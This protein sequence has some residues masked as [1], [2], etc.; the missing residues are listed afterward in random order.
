MGKRIEWIDQVKGFGIFLVV[1]GHNFPITEKYIYSFHMP[2]FFVV[3]GFFHPIIQNHKAIIKRAKTILVPY[4]LWSFL[5]FIF[6]AVLGRS[7]GES[8]KHN[9][10]VFKNFIGVFYAQGDREYMDW[11]IPMWF[12][13]TIFLTFLLFYLLQNIKGKT[14]RICFLVALIL[15]GFT[16]PYVTNIKF[17][18]SLDVALVSLS[19]YSFGFYIKPFIGLQLKSTFWVLTIIFGIIH[20]YLFTVNLKVD[21][22]RS[23]YGNEI[24]FLLNGVSGTLF[25]ISLFKIIPK[26]N[27]LGFIGKFT[28]PILALQIRSLTFI[29][30]ILVLVF[31][32][33]VFDFSESD[34]FFLSLIQLSLIIPVLFLIKNYVPILNGD[35]KK[36]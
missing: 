27:L 33:R 22:Y 12:L 5:L 21:M 24:L 34:K 25:Y 18:W 7:Y 11:G 28:I 1:Y 26:F 31:G 17:I 36:I 2:L 9:L 35:L 23:I 3:A 30:L 29:K 16:L 19:F 10:S 20:F 8:A 14:L 6:W 4:F 13:P 32:I 15:V